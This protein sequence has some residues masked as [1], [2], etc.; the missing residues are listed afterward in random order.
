MILGAEAQEKVF[1]KDYFVAR[2]KQPHRCLWLRP[3]RK[4]AVAVA[5]GPQIEARNLYAILEQSSSFPVQ[6]RVWYGSA[7]RLQLSCPQ[8]V[9]AWLDSEDSP[10]A[11]VLEAY[12]TFPSPIVKAFLRVVHEKI[13]IDVSEW[14]KAFASGDQKSLERIYFVWSLHA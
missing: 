10:S 6:Q 14:I 2:A 9:W 7:S 11:L 13:P 3:E 4:L 12:H 5:R 1:G 8:F